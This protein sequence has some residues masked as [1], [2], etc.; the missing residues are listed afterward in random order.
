M[1]NLI[2]SDSTATSSFS[3]LFDMGI[4]TNTD[5]TLKMTSSKFN[6]A[7]GSKLADM[8]KYFANSDDT[9]A[10]KNGMAQRIKS[11]TSQVLDTNGAIANSTDGIKATIKRNTTKIDT[12]NDR[13]SLYEARLRQQ[14]TA[15]DTTYSKFSGLQSYVSAQLAAL[16]K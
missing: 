5:G 14:Y 16:N 2:T 12:I 10:A 15:L 11:L 4:V 13:A 7:M 8:Q 1:R 9:V 3:R 6:D